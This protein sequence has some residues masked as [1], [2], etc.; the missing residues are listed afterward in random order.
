MAC[1]EHWCT[2]CGHTEFNN[3]AVMYVCKKCGAESIISHCD[4]QDDYER[5]YDQGD[6]DE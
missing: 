5:D 2:K 6:D 3:S 4:E 1:M